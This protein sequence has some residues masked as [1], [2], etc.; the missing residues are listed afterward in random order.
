MVPR[1]WPVPVWELN[2]NA[3][4]GAAPFT[5]TIALFAAETSTVVDGVMVPIP[6]LPPLLNM[7]EFPRSVVLINWA[8]KPA[9]PLAAFGVT[10][11]V[12]AL[13]VDAA[14]EFAAMEFGLP[15][16]ASV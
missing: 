11:F 2:R 4:P 1:S 14:M 3:A 10:A 7:L 5:R 12:L 13:P 15:S 8:I 16:D 9:L 6:M